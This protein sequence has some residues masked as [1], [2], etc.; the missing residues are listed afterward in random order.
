MKEGMKIGDIELQ[1]DGTWMVYLGKD[2]YYSAQNQDNAQ[3]ISMLAKI[4]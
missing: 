4:Q 2:L 3:I 1:D